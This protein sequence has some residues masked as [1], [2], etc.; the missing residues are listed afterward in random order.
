MFEKPF[1]FYLPLLVV[2]DQ[3]SR[4]VSNRWVVGLMV[5]NA[6]INGFIGK[7]LVEERVKQY[8][9]WDQE[10]ISYG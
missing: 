6:V 10:R 2:V 5:V 3:L 7:H 8:E 4:F 9:V 1:Y